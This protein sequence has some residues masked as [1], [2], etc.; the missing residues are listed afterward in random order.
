MHQA[1]MK[2]QSFIKTKVMAWLVV[3]SVDKAGR[4]PHTDVISCTF[5]NDDGDDVWQV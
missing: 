5:E 2:K 4:I 3:V 1:D